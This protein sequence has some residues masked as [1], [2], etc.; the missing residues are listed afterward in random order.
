MF[1]QNH[2]LALHSYSRDILKEIIG[3]GIKK[4]R[5]ALLGLG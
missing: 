2:S 4:S 1:Y 5:I 3:L